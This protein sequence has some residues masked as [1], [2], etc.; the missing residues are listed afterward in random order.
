MAWPV[1]SGKGAAARKVDADLAGIGE[2]A[3]RCAALREQGHRVRIVDR[4]LLMCG[5][6]V[7]TLTQLRGDRSV[8]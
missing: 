8:V 5:A 3:A 7:F 2:T 6:P 1:G 4:C